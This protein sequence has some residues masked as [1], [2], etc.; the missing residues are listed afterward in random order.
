MNAKVLVGYQA[1][2]AGIAL[3]LFALALPW[4]LGSPLAVAG[5]ALVAAVAERGRVQLDSRTEV[6]ISILPTVFAA[7]VFGPLA[8]MVVSAVSLIG[9]APLDRFRRAAHEPD[10]PRT[11]AIRWGI[12]TC[13]RAIYGATAGFA[14]AAV[15]PLAQNFNRATDTRDCDCSSR[16]RAPR[17]GVYGLDALDSTQ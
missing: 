7:A 17:L 5:L 9:D 13:S 3:A 1:C 2:L 11:P 12:F 15:A 14:A 6:S 10:R 16:R 8:G 4:G